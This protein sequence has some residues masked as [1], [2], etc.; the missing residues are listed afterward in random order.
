[1]LVIK[2]RG[3]PE[4]RYPAV[5]GLNVVEDA[6]PG[7]APAHCRCKHVE[8]REGFQLP[9]VKG[10]GLGVVQQG[11]HLIPR[12]LR[13]RAF[14]QGVFRAGRGVVPAQQGE[15][16]SF[17]EPY[18][19]LFKQFRA[20]PVDEGA[21]TLKLGK[22]A[23]SGKSRLPLPAGGFGYRKV[24]GVVFAGEF[25]YGPHQQ[26]LGVGEVPDADIIVV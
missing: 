3:F 16:P 15:P 12:C 19:Q 14:C 2:P 18:A 1:M 6:L 13:R 11:S 17:G 21:G 24:Q 8:P 7:A 23:V 22:D 4:H 10:R 9:G 26:V 5:T 20:G 25:L